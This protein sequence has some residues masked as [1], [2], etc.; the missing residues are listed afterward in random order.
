MVIIINIAIEDIIETSTTYLNTF[1]KIKLK[2]P[3]SKYQSE[4]LDCFSTIK[5]TIFQSGLQSKLSEVI[6]LLYNSGYQEIRSASLDVQILKIKLCLNKLNLLLDNFLLKGNYFSKVVNFLFNDA[7]GSYNQLRINIKN[8]YNCEEIKL[9]TEDGKKLDTMILYANSDEN[10][11]SQSHNPNDKL[12]NIE[13]YDEKEFSQKASELGQ[14]GDDL[15]PIKPNSIMIICNPNA[16]SFELLAYCDFWVDFYLS[17]NISVLLWNYRGYGDSEGYLTFEFMKRDSEKLIECIKNM[18]KFNSIGVHGISIGSIPACHLAGLNYVEFA[19]ID[20][21]FCSINEII[22]TF[23]FGNMFELVYRVLRFKDCSNVLNYIKSNCFKLI[24]CDPDDYIIK[25]IASLKSGISRDIMEFLQ[26][27]NVLG[28][29]NNTNILSEEK[30]SKE[31]QLLELLFESESEKFSNTVKIIIDIINQSC[32]HED[33]ENIK[34]KELPIHISINTSKY[35]ETIS[36]NEKIISMTTS[37][38]NNLTSSTVNNALFHKVN[39]NEPSSNVSKYEKD[40]TTTNDLMI[41]EDKVYSNNETLNLLY[42]LFNSLDSCGKRFITIDYSLSR[43]RFTSNLESYFRNL[44]IWGSHRINNR[45]LFE[46]NQIYNLMSK[47]LSLII[48]KVAKIA[49]NPDIYLI[50]NHNLRSNIKIFAGYMWRIEAFFNSIIFRNPNLLYHEDVED[51]L[52][53]ISSNREIKLDERYTT[54]TSNSMLSDLIENINIGDLLPLECGHNGV[55]SQI[56]LE[57]LH[58]ALIRSK[59]IE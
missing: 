54:Y 32:S 2:S 34:D 57:Y 49:D 14:D 19:F 6:K 30:I 3:I 38:Q 33:K 39:S 18:N 43:K 5:S 9:L 29:S 28:I 52:D 47:K 25:D 1:E 23:K 12:K 37:N 59:L 45:I 50:D 13:S 40:C 26:T 17:R 21:G 4:S 20:R 55:Y 15:K 35:K 11:R 31:F 46:K 53:I 48:K 58:H 24:S 27:K 56:E 7:F 22:K 16:I 8:T 42:S 44:L 36:H 51:D 10:T 41:T